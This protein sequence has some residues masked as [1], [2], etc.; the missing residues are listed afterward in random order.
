MHTLSH[1]LITTQHR[2][3]VSQKGFILLMIT[4]ENAARI[5][6]AHVRKVGLSDMLGS[7]GR[8]NTSGDSV[9][10][11]DVFADELLTSMLTACG[12]VAHMG[13]EEKTELITTPSHEAPYSI[14]F[15]PLD[16]SSNIDTG[17]P[18]GTIFSIYH[19]S[20]LIK[21][22]EP[23]LPQGSAQIAAGYILYGSTTLLVYATAE[24][25]EGFTL[26]PATGCFLHSHPHI[27][28]STHPK[29]YIANEANEPLWEDDTRTYVQRLKTT[30]T[31]KHRN[32]GCLVADFHTILISGGV[33]L[34]PADRKNKKVQF[35]WI[36][37]NHCVKDNLGSVLE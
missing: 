17:A 5:I 34:Y 26:D 28:I 16:G 19:T 4:L 25:V 15:D 8:L 22:R 3:P 29:I 20:A 14:F 31:I 24:G 13:S 1:H 37:Q 6:S 27:T 10:R 33:F 32:I 36:Y 2:E 35:Q 30:S 18:L 23:I 12:Q 7:S 11:I 21:G 9:K